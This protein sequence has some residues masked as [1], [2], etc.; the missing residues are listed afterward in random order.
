MYL[1]RISNLISSTNAYILGLLLLERSHDLEC[2]PDS[3]WLTLRTVPHYEKR[4]QARQPDGLTG[5]REISS[6]V[7]GT[8]A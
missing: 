7:C 2:P 4:Q 1:R 8:L 3:A 5:S 6:D